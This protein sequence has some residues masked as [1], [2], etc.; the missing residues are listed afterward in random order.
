MKPKFISAFMDVAE[1]FAQLSSAKKLQVGAIIVRDNRII[2]IGYNGTPTGWDNECEVI[3]RPGIDANAW[4]DP[5]T[6]VDQYPLTD[7]LGRYRLKTKEE[8]LHAEMNCIGKLAGSGESGRGATMFI[9][10]SPCMECA[11]LIHGAGIVQVF[12]KHEYRCTNGIEFLSEC[13]IDVIRLR[14]NT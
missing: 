4:L 8:V 6:L 5:D 9:T 7:D 10:H 12:Y 2:S 14:N 3:D 13:G 1:R 11:K